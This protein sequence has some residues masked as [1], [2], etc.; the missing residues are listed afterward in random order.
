MSNSIRMTTE[1][2]M[3]HKTTTTLFRIP[4]INKKDKN[5]A[6]IKAI[7]PAWYLNRKTEHKTKL[8]N[9]LKILFK[10]AL[11]KRFTDPVEKK[12]AGHIYSN[13]YNH[14]KFDLCD[15][16]ISKE[17]DADDGLHYIVWIENAEWSVSYYVEVQKYGRQLKAR[18]QEYVEENICYFDRHTLWIH[19]EDYKPPA[20]EKE[21]STF[22]DTDTKC[23]IC[24]EDYCDEKE[25]DKLH[26][27]GHKYCVD[28][29]DQ[30]IEFGK[31]SICR[32]STEIDEETYGITEE[33]IDVLCDDEDPEPLVMLMNAAGQMENF[34]S[35]CAN[36]DGYSHILGYEAEEDI[37]L[38][39]G[40]YI[41]MSRLDTYEHK[42]HTTHY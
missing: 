19:L 41:L 15:L 38:D 31:C 12:I 20:E 28:C 16:S 8:D 2:T 26:N 21:P 18:L 7:Y 17:P 36:G 29:I 37:E 34:C 10:E 5:G 32:T 30:V 35:Y 1:A 25:C 6:V 24:L 40:E 22:E 39:D 23:P 27:C 3:V 13:H 42:A 9:T 14:Y 11:M 33:D 4:V